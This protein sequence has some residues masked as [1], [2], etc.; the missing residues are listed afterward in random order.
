M[1]DARARRGKLHLPPPEV[2]E[3]AH[4]VF[5]FELAGHYVR[6]NE[7]FGV[8]V[9]AEPR[10]SFHAVFV[11]HAQRAKGLVAGVVVGRKR[12]RVEGV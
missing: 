6:P 10:S 4:A 2:F 7:E 3:I 1:P 9:R 8:R 11:D 12:K 5:V